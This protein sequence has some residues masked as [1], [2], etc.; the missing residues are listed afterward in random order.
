M[1]VYMFQEPIL[2]GK[3]LLSDVG[4]LPTGV[5]SMKIRCM[6]EYC[7]GNQG[8]NPYIAERSKYVWVAK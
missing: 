1:Y 7:H 2:Q 3:K 8:D 5:K 6:Q 4:M